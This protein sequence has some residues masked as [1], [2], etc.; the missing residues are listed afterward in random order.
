MPLM[1]QAGF[2]IFHSECYETFG[3][4]IMEA[5]ASGTPVLASAVGGHAEMI[6]EHENGLLFRVGNADDLAVKIGDMGRAPLAQMRRCAR[7]TF[8]ANYTA[9]PNYARLME[10][11]A[12]ARQHRRERGNA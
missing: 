1:R 11:Y 5:F 8:E 2:L 4:V 10:V 3:R 12:A 7:R 9:E 6:T